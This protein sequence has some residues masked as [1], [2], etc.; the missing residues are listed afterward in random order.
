MRVF[1]EK[2]VSDYE[3]EG[4]AISEARK[5]AFKS[6]YDKAVNAGAKNPS[7]DVS[8][9]EKRAP[10]SGA[11]DTLIEIRVTARASGRPGI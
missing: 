1:H 9:T 5:A 11:G 4:Q 3:S 8:V 7:V 10:V 2:G 6:A